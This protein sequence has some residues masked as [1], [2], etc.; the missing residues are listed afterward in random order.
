MTVK[1][2]MSYKTSE[3]NFENMK[4][5]E[6]NTTKSN[7]SQIQPHP[8][9][10]QA[11]H[12]HPIPEKRNSK[13]SM[14]DISLSTTIESTDEDDALNLEKQ[15]EAEIPWDNEGFIIPK[16]FLSTP[17]MEKNSSFKK[18]ALQATPSDFPQYR[19]QYK[20]ESIYV[21]DLYTLTYE[22]GETL[23]SLKTIEVTYVSNIY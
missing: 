20:V 13:T 16:L 18:L 5:V 23:E 6:K 11:V 15:F 21:N 19:R 7:D 17:V 9:E 22:E 1:D 3:F 10:S 14:E 8:M 12:H 2:P 4:Q